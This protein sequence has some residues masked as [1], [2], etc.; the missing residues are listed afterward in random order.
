MLPEAGFKVTTMYIQVVIIL[1][2]LAWYDGNSGNTT[3]PVGGKTANESGI[4]DM[5]GNVWEWC[6][7][8]ISVYYG[9]NGES[10]PVQS[11]GGEWD[12]GHSAGSCCPVVRGGSWGWPAI[13]C[14]SASRNRGVNVSVDST[15]NAQYNILG[16]RVCR[17]R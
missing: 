10:N 5:S 12:T 15:P 16:F 4:T 7:D 11:P 6:W 8:S 14:R 2:S 9:S 1:G 13:S 17:I 3:H